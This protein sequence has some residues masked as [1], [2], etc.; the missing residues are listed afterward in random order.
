MLILLPSVLL[1]VAALALLVLRRVRPGFGFSWLIASG[2]VSLAWIGLMPLRLR[3]PSLLA[4]ET[5]SPTSVF[6][7]SP[8]LSADYVSWPY[9]LALVTLAVAVILTATARYQSTISPVAWAGS[10]I[11]VSLG[12][13]SVM[14]ANL[15]TLLVT[16]VAIDLFDL[17]LSITQLPERRLSNRIVLTF[18]VR[19]IAIV[20]V[21]W[22][23]LASRSLGPPL[24]LGN[25][26]PQVGVYL[27]LGAGLRLGVLP[28]NLPLPEE[29][30]LRRGLGTVLRLVPAASGLVLLG[31]LPAAVA[32][33]AWMPYL[34]GFT[35]L[36]GL[37]G[38]VAWVGARDEF[39]GRTYWLVGM[40]ALAVASAINGNPAASTTWGVA[41][42]LGG[43]MLSLH[44]VR[45][46][47]FLFLPLLSLWGLAGLPFSPSAS[48]WQGLVAGSYGGWSALFILSQTLMVLGFLRHSL[49]LGEDHPPGMERWV[50]VIYPIGLLFLPATHIFL[51]LFGW[52]G[53]RTMGVWWAA[54]ASALLVVVLSL[55]VLRRPSEAAGVSLFSRGWFSPLARNFLNGVA[56]FFRLDWAYRILWVFYRWIGK[57]IELLTNILEGDGGILWVLL[58]LVLLLTVLQ[59]GIAP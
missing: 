13:L 17:V 7:S 34:L 56:S 23:M 49:R 6:P 31:R 36:A 4:L 46:R 2:A 28:L 18:S 59:E 39:S 58:L 15:V 12:L 29:L 9:A 47:R 50:Q 44:T 45:A 8:T 53:S 24:D 35:A 16:W 57:L 51:G 55:I 30:P 48:G 52:P 5:W 22:A 54:L 43:G 37:Y 3:L 32:P 20:V 19:I 27:L 42:L 14:S 11:M 26:D 25:I 10:L 33:P 40:A 38:G 21:L 41:L 1:M